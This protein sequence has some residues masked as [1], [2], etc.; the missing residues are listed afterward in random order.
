MLVVGMDRLVYRLPKLMPDRTIHMVDINERAV[1]LSRKNAEGNGVQ[2]VRIFESDGLSDVTE[3]GLCCN[4]NKPA[5]PCW[6]RN[7]FSFL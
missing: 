2:N 3:T 7:D 1:Q 5:D 6:K 4:F